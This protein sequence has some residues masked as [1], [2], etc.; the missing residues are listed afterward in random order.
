MEAAQRWKIAVAILTR[1]EQNSLILSCDSSHLTE[2]D[3]DTC[4]NKI[5]GSADLHPLIILDFSKVTKIAKL[6]SLETLARGLK[7]KNVKLVLLAHKILAEELSS[8]K[9]TDLFSCFIEA[10]SSDSSASDSLDYKNEILRASTEAVAQVI[11]KYTQMEVKNGKPFNQRNPKQYSV[12]IGG[13]IGVVGHHFNA[14]LALS[15]PMKTY[16]TIISKIRNKH[17]DKI[18][19]EIQDWAG[20]LA[21]VTLGH[22]KMLLNTDAFG[23]KYAVPTVVYAKDLEVFYLATQTTTIVPFTSE[24][25]TFYLEIAVSSD[26]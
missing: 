4:S 14:T 18:T 21:N 12:D 20:E 16:L 15:F 6:H 10:S 8:T 1:V 25:G 5:K 24:A 9:I 2:N 7:K 17:Y 19:P 11:K 23:I 26:N 22:V 3:I 13:I